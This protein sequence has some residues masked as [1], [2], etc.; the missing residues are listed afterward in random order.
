M[1][2]F[3]TRWL[4]IPPLGAGLASIAIVAL[5][6]PAN[7][8]NWEKCVEAIAKTQHELKQL[9]PGP[10]QPQSQQQSV[11]AQDSQQ[12]TPSSLAAAGLNQPDTGAAGALNEALNLQAAGDEAG[13]MKAVAKARSLAG[14]K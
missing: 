12:P 7:A 9:G 10:T 8:Q 4:G 3:R 2:G 5:A 11:Q 13:C 6:S 1:H 14:L